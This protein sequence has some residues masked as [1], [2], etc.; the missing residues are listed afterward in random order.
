DDDLHPPE[1]RAAAPEPARHAGGVAQRRDGSGAGPR[2]PPAARS[3][4]DDRGA[5][6]LRR[7]LAGGHAEPFWAW[8]GDP[9]GHAAGGGVRAE[10][11]P[12]SAAAAGSRAVHPYTAVGLSRRSAPAAGRPGP[13]AR[14]PR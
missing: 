4:P 10:R 5:G 7:R 8:A 2:V 9:L 13:A 11:L 12:A 3:A 6:A 1:D 14:P